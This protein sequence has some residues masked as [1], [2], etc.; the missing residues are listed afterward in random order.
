LRGKFALFQ[1]LVADVD[2]YLVAGLAFVGL[3][4]RA[5]TPAAGLGSQ[6][7]GLDSVQANQLRAAWGRSQTARESRLA[8]APTFGFGLNFFVNRFVS[9]NLEYRATP[10]SA[11]IARAPTRAP[12]ARAAAWR[13]P[14]ACEGFSDY[15]ATYF[16]SPGGGAP[17]TVID[18]NDRTLSFNQMV[19]LGLTFFLPTQPRIGP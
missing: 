10:L 8:V 13:A 12:P 18:E 5:E 7:A 2:F 19:N 17:R 16:P 4:E 14:R 3:S 11:G 6:T 9:L 15:L 1:N